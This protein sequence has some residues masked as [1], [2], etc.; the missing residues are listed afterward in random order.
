MG[1]K[2]QTYDFIIQFARRVS[3]Y[4]KLLIELGKDTPEINMVL[5][6]TIAFLGNAAANFGV[7]G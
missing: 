3:D 5:A 7:P 6:E 2:M 4:Q 1:E